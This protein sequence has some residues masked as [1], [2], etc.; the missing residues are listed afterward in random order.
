MATISND[1]I[2]QKLQQASA[3]LDELGIDLWMTFVQETSA[4]AERAFS[5]I[6]PGH[7]TWESAVLV[8]KGGH[9][10]VI[11]G[12]M[13][14]PDFEKSGLYDRV[15][16][17]MKDFLEP[18]R[19][20]LDEHKPRKVA[21]NYSLDDFAADGISHGSFL[22][23]EGLFKEHLPE[24]EIVS[25]EKIIGSLISQKSPLE[26]AAIEEGVVHTVA[27]FDEIG[28]FLK[29]GRTELEVYGF[30]QERME[31]RGLEPSFPTLV[32]A[33]DRGAGM[34]HATATDNDL[35]PGDLI[36][37][38][39]GV[40]VRGYASDMQRTWYVLRPGEDRAPKAVQ[41]GFDTIA[42]AIEEAGKAVVPG[43]KGADVDG[44][45][46]KIITDA[47]YP[48]YPH[49]LG[50]QIGQEA[51]DGGA[52]LCPAW[53]RY[54]NT[55]FIPLMEGQ[56]FTLEPSLNVEGHGAVGLEEDVVVTPDGAR[57]L[58]EPQRELWYVRNA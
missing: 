13:D 37:V 49:G 27:I 30:V 55:P 12:Q 54:K 40:M 45:A 20:F 53:P 21:L 9:K 41:K 24:A 38:D 26:L 5:Y 25:A 32:F 15:S 11:C 44:I 52:L 43:A 14:H 50:H 10:E 47:G 35:R 51:H 42:H 17:Y 2:A 19:A 3:R 8:T 34:G 39:M 58:H 28:K 31:A 33:G 6:S 46:R 22:H 23:L 18:F 48:E 4:G 57:Y 1:I 56:I 36:H 16:P 29:V 7:L